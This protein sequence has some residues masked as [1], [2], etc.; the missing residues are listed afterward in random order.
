MADTHRYLLMW[1]SCEG[2]PELLEAERASRIRPGT[3]I[4]VSPDGEVDGHLCT[5][6]NSFSMASRSK[7][8]LENIAYKLKTYLEWL[9]V[10]GVS[11]SE[12]SPEDL[13]DYAYW[14]LSDPANPRPLQP[15]SWNESLSVLSRFYK[16]AVNRGWLTR[17][18]VEMRQVSTDSETARPVLAS[19]NAKASNVKFVLPRAY[20]LWREVGIQ[21]RIA[22]EVS[23]GRWAPGEVDDSRSLR[24]SARNA[25][26]AD[27]LMGSGLRRVEAGTLLMFEVPVVDPSR[28]LQQG[29]VGAAVSKT[30]ARLFYVRSGAV[31]SL[32]AYVASERKSAVAAAQASG[33]YERTPGL[34]VVESVRQARE[35][36]YLGL[37]TAD[38]SRVERA[39]ASLNADDRGSLFRRNEG[40]LL[41]PLSLFLDVRGLPLNPRNWNR[42]F[43]TANQAVAKAGIENLRVHP[44]ALRHSFAITMLLSLCRGL[45][46]EEAGLEQERTMGDVFEILRQLMGHSSVETTRSHY[47]GPLRGLM[48]EQ[49]VLLTQ[50]DDVEAFAEAIARGYREIVTPPRLELEAS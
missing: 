2:D 22:L 7:T 17:S 29:L 43:Q 49:I 40:G 37:R 1:T 31:A 34:V 28:A 50:S 32:E 27:L 4:L 23:H 38:G 13:E 39:L 18:P 47:L 30:G 26:F 19:S 48:A 12:A 11:W 44:H 45:R 24:V 9:H 15:G 10:Q 36:T 20:E 46:I 42:E 3:P 33:L 6:F 21:G 16:F 41:E 25:A 14:R 35:S 5:Y 8:A